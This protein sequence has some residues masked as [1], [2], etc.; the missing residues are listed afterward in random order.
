MLHII[1]HNNPSVV[2]LFHTRE[3]KEEADRDGRFR[4]S[5]EAQAR[6]LGRDPG[7][8]KVIDLESDIADPSDFNA[9]SKAYREHFGLITQQYPEAEIMINV[10]SGT[11]QMIATASIL[12]AAQYLGRTYHCI[13]VVSP[14]GRS[15]T[16]SPYLQTYDDNEIDNLLDNLP[17]AEM[18]CRE[19]NIL[20]FTDSMTREQFLELL[21]RYDYAGAARL[22]EQHP[23]AINEHTMRWVQHMEARVAN[24]LATARKALQPD[25]I[26]EF[27][28]YPVKNGQVQPMYEFYLGILVK[29]LRG[30]WSDFL[31]RLSPLLTELI[32]FQIEGRMRFPLGQLVRNEDKGDRLVRT[33]VERNNPRLILY[34][35][36]QFLKFRDDYLSLS[37]MVH[38]LNY[39]VSQKR[40]SDS[41]DL[42]VCDL[43]E[44]LRSIEAELRN[45]VAHQMVTVSDNWAKQTVNMSFRQI[46]R[47]LEDLLVLVMKNEFGTGW[48]DL[49]DRVN[50]HIARL[51]DT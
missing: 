44:Q 51:V 23:H 5:I 9:F 18:R 19:P 16:K 6:T 33:L 39:A 34:L 26:R 12:A 7:T 42:K 46:Q 25:Y 17:D 50:A 37:N 14:S 4:R 2:Y 30:E 11:P 20:F 29:Y 49:P 24:D 10:S 40:D 21:K 47:L 13:Q 41:N 8:I 45:Q 48:R 3:M 38:V 22:A 28:P 1:R 15:G 43:F 27:D 32:R 35:D 31:I 36:Q